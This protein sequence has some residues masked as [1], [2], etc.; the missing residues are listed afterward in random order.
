MRGSPDSNQRARGCLQ[1]RE[2]PPSLQKEAAME[3]VGTILAYALFFGGIV[4]V[5]FILIKWIEAARDL[6]PRH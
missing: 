5:G 1:R 6:Y 3:W 2:E 4:L